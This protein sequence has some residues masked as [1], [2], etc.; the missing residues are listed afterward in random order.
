MNPQF[1]LV[2]TQCPTKWVYDDPLCKPTYETKCRAF[3]PSKMN[4]ADR[5]AFAEKCGLIWS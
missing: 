4:K 5:L 2:P 1:T 3:D